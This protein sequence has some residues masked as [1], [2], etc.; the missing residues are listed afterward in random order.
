MSFS[1]QYGEIQHLRWRAREES[2][3]PDEMMLQCA[4]Y[5]RLYPETDLRTE[6]GHQLR[7]LSPGWWN[8]QEGPDFKGAQIEFNGKLHKGD[9]EIHCASKGWAAHG[10]HRDTRYDAVILHVVFGGEP[11]QA[12]AITSCGRR[13]PTLRLG[14]L[15]PGDW[16]A[17]TSLS[18]M[19]DSSGDVR[20]GPGRCAVRGGL[21]EITALAELSGDW[22]MLNKARAMRERME[23][24]GEQ[25]A[26]YEELLYASGFSR[27]KHHFRAIARHLPYDRAR[28]LAQLDPLL[29]ECA[30]LQIAGLLPSEL[31]DETDDA[32][33]FKKLCALRRQHLEGL[34]FLPL[35]WRRLGIRP[36]NYPERR[37]AGA[38]LLIARTARDGFS[39]TLENIWGEDITPLD[40]RKRF[41]GLFPAAMGFWAEHCTWMGKRM[42]HPSAPL[43]S[44]RVRSIIGNVF[45]PAAL[46]LAR[47]RGDRSREERVFEF[48]KALPA[49]PGNRTIKAMLPRIF[50]DQEAVRLD[51]RRQQGLLQLYEDWCESN[52]SCHH[53]AILRY[54]ENAQ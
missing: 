50:G 12:A 25:Q 49:E 37:L 32:A 16:Q 7:V 3:S 51:F 54:L 47:I 26:I 8:H 52:P 46:S 34:R 38:A 41:E 21:K 13:I 6:E 4:W 17:L 30:L 19:D 5:E 29:L 14:R 53:C 33:H 28:Q 2:A 43:G 40:R 44:G 9:V 1:V 35:E 27:F 24:V 18:R 45:I 31:P 39:E 48:Y 15:L 20:P 10:H 36:A 23:C 11:E 42:T 22:R